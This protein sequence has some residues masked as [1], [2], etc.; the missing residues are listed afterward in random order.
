MLVGY[1]NASPYPQCFNNLNIEN[2]TSQ[3]QIPSKENE[4]KKE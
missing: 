3:K 1:Q 2:N 4:N